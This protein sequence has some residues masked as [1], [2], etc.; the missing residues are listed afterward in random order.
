M[1]ST[2]IYSTFIGLKSAL[3][4]AELS[5]GGFVTGI[6]RGFVAVQQLIV[7]VSGKQP[8][9]AY[10]FALFLSTYV[11]Y[12]VISRARGYTDQTALNKLATIDS[13][14]DLQGPTD[15]GGKAL[16]KSVFPK[17]AKRMAA[18]ARMELHLTHK[19]RDQVVAVK[20]WARRNLET[21]NVR[22]IDIVEL[23]PHIVVLA[24]L[25]TRAERAARE[26]MLSPE[27]IQRQQRMDSRLFTYLG[28]SWEYPLGRFVFE[29]V[30]PEK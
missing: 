18:I 13:R 17:L 12:R 26:M 7:G 14:A 27:F 16:K 28:P 19:S 24:F 6:S 22:K 4:I 21:M 9:Y 1:K 2:M 15:Y 29:E 10:A 3:D 20:E 11:T 5:V 23:L 8:A 30:V 25:E